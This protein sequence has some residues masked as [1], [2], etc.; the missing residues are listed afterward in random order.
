MN[1]HHRRPALKSMLPVIA[2]PDSRSP[3][4]SPAQSTPS[5]KSPFSASAAASEQPF[6][7][8]RETDGKSCNMSLTSR[9]LLSSF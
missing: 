3:T 7:D 1:G 5:Q 6:A 8:G 4:A 9:T 2:G